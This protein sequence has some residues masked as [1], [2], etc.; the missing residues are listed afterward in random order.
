MNSNQNKPN[1]L[2]SHPSAPKQPQ[3]NN[4]MQFKATQF[5]QHINSRQTK[6]TKQNSAKQLNSNLTESNRMKSKLH[7]QIQIT[8]T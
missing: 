1:Q 8:S 3:H 6:E 2:K 7:Q 4:A 5:K